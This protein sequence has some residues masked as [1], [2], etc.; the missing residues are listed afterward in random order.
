[1]PPRDFTIVTLG[2]KALRVKGMKPTVN[3]LK[4]ANGKPQTRFGKSTK[5]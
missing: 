3:V 1:M 5:A 4:A 2:P